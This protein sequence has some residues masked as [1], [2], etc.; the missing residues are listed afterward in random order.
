MP[1]ALDE[2]FG[3][4]LSDVSAHRVSVNTAVENYPICLTVKVLRHAPRLRLDGW[5]TVVETGIGTPSGRLG[6]T[7]WETG[8]PLPNLAASGPGDYRVR[9]HVRNQEEAAKYASDLPVEEHL[10]IV[11]PGTSRRTV[12][13]SAG[14]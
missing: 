11:Y 12:F 4:S 14:R 13:L 8:D 6:L 2:A 9:I 7:S 3:A 10:V 5:D 1:R